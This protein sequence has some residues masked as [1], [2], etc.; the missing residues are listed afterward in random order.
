LE[1]RKNEEN[2]VSIHR[3][4]KMLIKNP[5]RRIQIVGLVSF[6]LPGLVLVACNAAVEPTTQK[7]SPTDTATA[8]P[9]AAEEKVETTQEA[10][11]EATQTPTTEAATPTEMPQQEQAVA[12]ASAAL[13][14][15]FEIPDNT[16]L[17]PAS[18]EDWAKGP[19]NASVTVIE[20]G[21]F[22]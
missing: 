7:A 22:Q 13:C 19:A 17:S 3:K 4:D 10:V 8:A 11:K 16:L 14:E 18:D 15:P 21:D 9:A 12:S 20:Y 2:L 6:L 5:W 1:T